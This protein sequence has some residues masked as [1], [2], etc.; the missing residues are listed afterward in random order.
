M[1]QHEQ[2]ATSFGSGLTEEIGALLAPVDAELER[3]YPGDPGTRQPVHTVYVPAD[4]FGPATLRDW[5]DEALDALDAHAPDS[6]LLRRRPRPRRRPGRAGLRPRPRQAHPRARR[7]P[8]HRL[9]GRLRPPPGRRGGRGGRPRRPYRRR[10]LRRRQRRP[11]HGHP[12]EVHGG[13]RPRPRHPH[14]RPL[15]HHPARLRTAPLRPGPHPPQGHLRRPGHRHGPAAGGVREEP[16]AGRRT[17]RL[18][19]PDRDQPVHP[20]PR[21]DRH[22]RPHDRRRRGPRHRPALRHLRL[23]R[24]PRRRRRPPGQRPP[25][26]RPRQ[27]RHAGRRRRRPESGSA[28][29]PPTSCPSAPPP[30]STTPGA[31]TTA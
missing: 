10:R 2:A 31:S 29:V 17:A 8:A 7:G 28:T 19:D 22:R 5:G 26:R 24:L 15:P 16:R 23:Q 25:G 3:R 18:R 11:V 13:R 12:D 20:R 1:G 21:R 6:R 9:R 4:A 27:G 14:P 30:R